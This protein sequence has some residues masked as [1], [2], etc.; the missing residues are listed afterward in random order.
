SIGDRLL[1]F[2]ANACDA[3]QA[4]ATVKKAREVF[5][6]IDILVNNVGGPYRKLISKC[7]VKDFER[8]FTLNFAST[9]AHIHAVINDMT[10]ERKGVIVNISSLAAFYP[11]PDCAF[12]SPAK[13]ALEMYTRTLASEVADSG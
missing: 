10:S 1:P 13:A 7:D 2:V 9:V 8:D 12:Y 5:G 4:G 3:A 11:A 6:S